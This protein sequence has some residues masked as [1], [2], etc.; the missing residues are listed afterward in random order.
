MIDEHR[1][2]LVQTGEL[3]ARRERRAAA[4][5]EAIALGTLR[6][7]MKDLRSG[8]ALGSLAHEVADG[9]LDPYAAAARLLAQLDQ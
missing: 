1:A 8:T 3:R 6:A 4:E 7:R 2:H 9:R 5:V